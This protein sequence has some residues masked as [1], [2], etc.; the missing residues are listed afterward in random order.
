MKSQENKNSSRNIENKSDAKD[1]T[2]EQNKDSEHP[3][4]KKVDK[5]ENKKGSK[6]FPKGASRFTVSLN[7]ILRNI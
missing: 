7:I 3:E 6:T 2:V 4:K 5:N 1:E